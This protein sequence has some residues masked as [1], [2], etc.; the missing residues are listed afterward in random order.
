[1]FQHQNQTP[2]SRWKFSDTPTHTHSSR[3]QDAY[4][5]ILHYFSSLNVA[6]ACRQVPPSASTQFRTRKERNKESNNT[7]FEFFQIESPMQL[8][9]LVFTKENSIPKKEKPRSYE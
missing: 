3:S 7:I 8:T 1:M 6:Y 4:N 2:R 5:F 9:W